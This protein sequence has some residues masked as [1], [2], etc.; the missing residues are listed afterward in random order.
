M[1][2]VWDDDMLNW[3]L[4]TYFMKTTDGEIHI[5]TLAIYV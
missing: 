4:K 5:L 2:K 1:V 3:N